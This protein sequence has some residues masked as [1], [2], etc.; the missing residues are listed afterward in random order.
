MLFKAVCVGCLVGRNLFTYLRKGWL[1]GGL[2]SGGYS[3]VL[4]VVDECSSVVDVRERKE[5]KR[6]A[7]K[8]GG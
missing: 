5:R 2:I 6:G 4:S 8:P 7:L 1:G 3:E